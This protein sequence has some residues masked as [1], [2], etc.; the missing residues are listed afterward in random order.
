[1]PE[2][3]GLPRSQDE[4]TL[5]M[6]FQVNTSPLG[7]GRASRTSRQSSNLMRDWR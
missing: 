5:A 7:A 6:M 1:M 2:S 4:T 3:E